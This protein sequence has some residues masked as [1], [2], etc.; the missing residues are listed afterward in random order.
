[1]LFTLSV[2]YQGNG[3]RLQSAIADSIGFYHCYQAD[4]HSL[5]LEGGEIRFCQPAM[6]DCLWQYGHFFPS[7]RFLPGLATNYARHSST[8]ALQ[9]HSWQFRSVAQQPTEAGPL[10]NS[11]LLQ[12]AGKFKFLPLT[13]PQSYNSVFQLTREHWEFQRRSNTPTNLRILLAKQAWVDR[14]NNWPNSPIIFDDFPFEFK[15][16]SESQTTHLF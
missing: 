1:M 11:S 8:C 3:S 9:C 6:R 4:Q 13:H 7:L 10:I 16:D 5:F 15:F 2:G 14:P 12:L